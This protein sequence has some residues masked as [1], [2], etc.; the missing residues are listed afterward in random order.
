M[1]CTQCYRS[2]DRPSGA[3]VRGGIGL[4]ESFTCT[5]VCCCWTQ[6]CPLSPL[7]ASERLPILALPRTCYLPGG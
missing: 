5:S 6:H 1:W 3:P 7:Q 4:V 2:R